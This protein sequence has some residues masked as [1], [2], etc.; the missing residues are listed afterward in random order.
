MRWPFFYRTRAARVEL[1]FFC[2]NP[3]VSSSSRMFGVSATPGSRNESRNPHVQPCTRLCPSFA[4]CDP[5]PRQEKGP[6]DV[7]DVR[8]LRREG[9]HGQFA[10]MILAWVKALGVSSFILRIAPL[11]DT[12]WPC[13]P[14]SWIFVWELKWPFGICTSRR[15]NLMETLPIASSKSFK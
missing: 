11:I 8:Q 7:R 14:R 3:E 10:Y 13:A 2:R 1:L 6:D 15:R 4:P 5:L 12:I 9:P